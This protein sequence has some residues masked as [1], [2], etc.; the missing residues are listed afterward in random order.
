MQ[1]HDLLGADIPA[2][3]RFQKRGFL[4]WESSLCPVKVTTTFLQLHFGVLTGRFFAS[5][6]WHGRHAC[7]K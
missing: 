1:F 3:L 2:R 5:G 6:P 7:G 4:S